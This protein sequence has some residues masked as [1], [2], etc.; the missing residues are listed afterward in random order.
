MPRTRHIAS[1]AWEQ[2]VWRGGFAK[3]ETLC[4]LDSDFVQIHLR[5]GAIDSATCDAC[6]LLYLAEKAESR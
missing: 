2:Y 5:T 4:G 3:R 1:I 6:I